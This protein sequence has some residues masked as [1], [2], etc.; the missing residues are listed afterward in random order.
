MRVVPAVAS[1]TNVIGASISMSGGAD[2]VVSILMPHWPITGTLTGMSM[3]DFTRARTTTS[4]SLLPC[5]GCS[6]RRG[7]SPAWSDRSMSTGP[8]GSTALPPGAAHRRAAAAARRHVE[9]QRQL[10]PVSELISAD[11]SF[12]IA[13]RPVVGHAQLRGVRVALRRRKAARD[14]RHAAAAAASSAAARRG[15]RAATAPDDT[16]QSNCYGEAWEAHSA[17]SLAGRLPASSG[18]TKDRRLGLGAG[19]ARYWT[20][21]WTTR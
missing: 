16:N 2:V 21:P 20:S 1:C 7:R 4:S 10:L 11:G 8:H 12:V 5:C 13:A 14:R 9:R 3:P 6:S 15:E 17:M 19:R 18:L